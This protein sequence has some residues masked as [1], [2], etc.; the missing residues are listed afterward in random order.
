MHEFS[1]TLQNFFTFY[2]ID[3][4]GLSV[5]AAQCA[6]FGFLLMSVLGT[7]MGGPLTDRFDRRMV[8]IGS[9]VGAAPFALALPWVG[10]AAVIALALIVSFVMSSA[11][12]AIL[13]WALDVA[14]ERVGMVSGLFFDAARPRRKAAKRKQAQ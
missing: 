11:F 12:T 9:I 13:V 14:P 2:L 10:L 1:T 5:E 7:V 6:L 8:I 4:F 3:A